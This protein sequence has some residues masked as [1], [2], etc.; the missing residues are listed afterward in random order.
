M[1]AVGEW[2]N[3]RTPR[4]ERLAE[5]LKS[6]GTETRTPPNIQVAIWNKFMFIASVGGVGGVTRVP[7][8]V[9]RT[10]PESRSLLKRAMEEIAALAR[11][12]G[13]PVG[14]KEF[15]EAWG[16]VENVPPNTTASM[17]RDVMDGRPSELREMS[18]A[19][20]RLGRAKGVSTPVHEFIYEAL[21]PQEMKAR[22]DI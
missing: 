5:A 18:G 4:L 21:L 20:V 7:I 6:T 10:V 17:Q 9:I 16:F 14:E 22:K 3:E 1:V 11:E 15:G 13:V 12:H 2:N 8:G 19:V